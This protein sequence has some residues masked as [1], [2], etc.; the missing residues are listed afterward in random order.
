MRGV[1]KFKDSLVFANAALSGYTL[2]Q[3]DSSHALFESYRGGSRVA[4]HTSGEVAEKSAQLWDQHFSQTSGDV[5]DGS[6]F[7]VEVSS[8]QTC[9]PV[10]MSLDLESPLG[11]AAFLANASNHRKVFIPSTFNMSKIVKSVRAQESVDLV[12]DKDFF[13]AEL[14]GP[15]EAE[16]KEMCAS[17]QNVIVA[18]EGAAGSSALF[19]Q[20]N[21]TVIDHLK[22]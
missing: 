5:P 19:G 10:F 16:Y 9:K 14:P 22:F 18:G 1:I 11:F 15:V 7:N 3:N 13:E 6:L 12:C 2:P 21:T 20:A 17:V 4:Q 8:G